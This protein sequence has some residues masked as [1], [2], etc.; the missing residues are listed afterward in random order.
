LATEPKGARPARR[1]S[2]LGL[3]A[4]LLRPATHRATRRRIA[5]AVLDRSAGAPARTAATPRA[6][7]GKAAAAR[8]RAG[9]VDREYVQAWSRLATVVQGRPVGHVDKRRIPT[10]LAEDVLAKARAQQ[11]YAKL[12]QTLIRG[13]RIESAVYQSVSELLTLK[14]GPAAWALAEGLGR[15]PGGER[16]SLV[17]HA[18]FRHRR[19]QRH[20][21]W[22]TIESLSDAELATFLPVE[23]VDGAF[24]AGTAEAR[25]RAIGIAS[26]KRRFSPTTLVNLAGRFL[27][28]G[29]P[30]VAG[31]LVAE[32]RQR[33]EKASIELDARRRQ[34]LNLIES[35]LTHR[36]KAVPAGA[37]PVAI[38]DYQTPDQSFASGNVGDYVQTLGLL[39]NL[40]RMTD[41][42]FSGE[43]G[44]GELATELQGRVQPRL[45]SSD[46]RGHIHLLD[47]NR[48]ASSLDE[49]PPNTWMIAFGWH[50]HAQFHL[51]DDFPYH[52]NIRPL[53]VS[54]HINRLDFL[55]DESLAYLRKYGP[56][57]CRDWTTV[58]LLLSAGVDAFFT[59]CLTTTV[60]ALF[61][62][63][64]SV[65][66]GS[67]DV[68]IID[69]T[70]EQAG[71]TQP[72]LREFTHQSNIYR[73]MSLT[74][75][76]QAASDLLG[77][78]QRELAR[79][80][81]SR[82]HAYLPLVSLGVPVEFKPKHPGDVRFTG[83]MDM[84]PGKPELAEIQD[85]IRELIAR[86]LG[87]ALSGAS[88][89]EVYA[90]WRELTADRLA[91]AKA[92]FAAPAEALQTSVDVAAALSGLRAG[93]A[94]FGP[95]DAVDAGSVTDVVSY[96]DEQLA[97]HVPTMVESLVANASGPV[98]LTLL[99][100]GVGADY[101]KWFA[102]AF[103]SV[104]V[105]F[106]A[107]DGLAYGG[108][109]AEQAA[110]DRLLIPEL[111]ADV[112]RAVYLEPDSLVLGD[113]CA[114]ARLGLDGHPLAARDAGTPEAVEWRNAAKELSPV[115]AGE[116]RRR[117]AMQHGFGQP[118]LQGG[119]LVLD[120]ARLRADGF[121][122]TYL[123]WV[124]R[125]RLPFHDVVLAYA[126]ADRVR[127]EPRW[128]AVLG[129][130]EVAD[131]AIVRWVGFSKP[132]RAPLTFAQDE[133]RAYAAR[134]RARAEAGSSAE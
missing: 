53:F 65:Y 103:P 95:A 106:Y 85:G 47:V 126:G 124:E 117:M 87:R 123:G 33:G 118:A 67:P 13:G 116:L 4:A 132:W 99:T 115:D 84:R 101:P 25:K 100:R 12:A 119:V 16:A 57:G 93:S 14:D 27:V 29:E 61:P 81:T 82:L 110:Q 55:N 5:R 30:A 19:G 32:L 31:E 66:S 35:W 113:V 63:R 70:R 22:P 52:P 83:L 42:E 120:L 107:C 68:A 58:D 111:L 79:V 134:V 108:S 102:S 75:G 88:E 71:L 90:Y 3:L 8:R 127:L 38:V 73:R 48:D 76:V 20:R 50:M 60:D 44:L 34:S 15:L 54:F 36:P 51:R 72:R 9:R 94:R 98:R 109:A 105:T 96:V 59:G 92:R 7:A 112:D 69:I 89:D 28:C 21:V 1:T 114:L 121:T 125:Y 62:D 74:E 41:V 104:P 128:S 122:T 46:A 18:V 24:L 91:A 80:T 49:V 10:E 56:V 40:V 11:A 78:Y 77:M 2:R 97:P 23:A 131:P 39:G 130:E 6:R 64:D 17:G 37:L 26:H 133:W 129:A 43:F 45:R 86:T